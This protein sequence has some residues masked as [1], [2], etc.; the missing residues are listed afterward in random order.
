V[1]Q[2]AFVTPKKLHRRRGEEPSLVVAGRGQRWL[3]PGGSEHTSRR[4]NPS[5][6]VTGAE[7]VW[8]RRRGRGGDEV[9]VAAASRGFLSL[10]AFWIFVLVVFE[11]G[12]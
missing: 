7:H 10:E 9:A 8:G 11:P 6:T 3:E 5:A 4:S 12:I 2:L 1:G